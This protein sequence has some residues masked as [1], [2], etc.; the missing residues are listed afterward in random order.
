VASATP[1]GERLRV[2]FTDPAAKAEAVERVNAATRVTDIESEEASLEDLFTS[3]TTEDE[4]SDDA[5][6]APAEVSA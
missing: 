5:V 6:E 4:P 1:D 2:A 3:Y